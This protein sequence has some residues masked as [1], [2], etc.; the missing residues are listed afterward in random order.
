MDNKDKVRWGILGGGR[1]ANDFAN[2]LA[3]LSQAKIEAVASRSE[4]RASQFSKRHRAEK[5]YTSYEELVNDPEVEIIY[6]ATTHNFHKDHVRLC[7][8]NG[9]H[10]LC[11][12]PHGKKL[13]TPL[14]QHTFSNLIQ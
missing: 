8:E 13:M 1:I 10:V 7:L 2:C 12:K 14:I 9:K 11:E 4:E 6:V 5:Y 3:L